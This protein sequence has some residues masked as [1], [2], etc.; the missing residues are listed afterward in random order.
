M[1]PAVSAVGP[2]LVMEARVPGGPV[3]VPTVGL[4]GERVTGAISTPQ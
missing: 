1:S 2:R 4:A 3:P